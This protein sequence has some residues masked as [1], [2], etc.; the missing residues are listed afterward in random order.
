VHV[1]VSPK[2]KVV[3][4]CVFARRTKFK[5]LTSFHNTKKLLLD[6]ATTA[7]ASAPDAGPALAREALSTW[8]TTGTRSR[9]RSHLI[10]KAS[11]HEWSR[12]Q[13]LWSPE[14]SQPCSLSL[15]RSST[16]RPA[17]SMP[18][19]GTWSRSARPHHDRSP[20][21]ITSFCTGRHS[22]EHSRY[23]VTTEFLSIS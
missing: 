21:Y 16:R 22:L 7:I 18:S 20:H 14:I 3:H 2:P 12:P 13:N 4:K 6:E 8:Q 19:C 23:M 11:H 1:S 15:P 17:R 9:K 10:L 5:I